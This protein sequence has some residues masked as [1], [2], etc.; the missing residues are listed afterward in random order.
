MPFNASSSSNATL[1]PPHV[2]SSNASV[3]ADLV[4]CFYSRPSFLILVTFSVTNIVIVLPPCILILHLGL[5]R[6]QKQSSAFMTATTS[7]SDVFT[8]H[9]VAIEMTGILGCGLYCFGACVNLP[10]LMQVGMGI[11][12]ITSYGQQVF[13][14]LSCVDRYLAVVHPITYLSLRKT[15]GIRIRNVSIG[16]VWLLFL[17]LYILN[18]VILNNSIAPALCLLVLSILVISFCSLSV[19]HALIRPGP[20]EGGTDRE[21]VHQSKLRAFRT[22]MIIM[23]VLLLRF[24][25]YVLV[26][27]IYF[28]SAL[29]EHVRC[30]LLLA[31]VWFSLPSSLVLPLLFLHRAGKLLCR[32][33]NTETGR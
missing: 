12:S 30:E 24:G 17:G 10:W 20:G 15:E 4:S 13:D 2:L 18:N 25:G 21:R 31:G 11:F 6:W 7:H 26:L 27:A 9:V 16:C 23:G 19:L 33:S 8:Y 14:I 29:R 28:F 32:N 5:Q 22:I 3:N 1:L